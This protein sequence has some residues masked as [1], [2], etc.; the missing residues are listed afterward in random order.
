[1]ARSSECTEQYAQKVFDRDPHCQRRDLS[2]SP[3]LEPYVRGDGQYPSAESDGTNSG[4]Y[5]R[6]IQPLTAPKPDEQAPMPAPSGKSQRSGSYRIP[7]KARGAPTSHVPHCTARN[8]ATNGRR[9]GLPTRTHA[10]N[11]PHMM[12]GRATKVS[13]VNRRTSLSGFIANCTPRP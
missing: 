5:R 13:P 2:P 8:H 4:V 10:T 6:L 12:S 1:M 7:I 9:F 11:R 3:F